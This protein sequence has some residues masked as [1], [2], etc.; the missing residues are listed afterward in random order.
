MTFYDDVTENPA[1]RYKLHFLAN[2]ILIT[3]K[4][5]IPKEIML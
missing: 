1:Q 4:C 2:C 5:T 3:Q